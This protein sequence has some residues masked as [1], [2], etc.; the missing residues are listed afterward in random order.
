VT[1]PPEAGPD[2]A[3]HREGAPGADP[4]PAAPPGTAPPGT[5]PPGTADRAVEAPWHRLDPRMLVVGPLRNL[6]GLVPFA[7]VLLVTGQGEVS[8]LWYAVGAAGLLVLF[9]VLRW[10][11]T[12]YRITA[13]RVELRTGVLNRQRRSVPRDRIRTVDTTAT[14]PHR[15][16]GL[17][18]VQVSAAAAGV[19]GS[20]L[21]LDAVSKPEAERLRLVLLARSTVVQ[22]PSAAD[23]AATAPGEELAR[24]RWS[25]IRFA[26]LTVSS[27]VA[28]AAVVG[29]AVNLLDDLRVVTGDLVGS[30]G[31]RV[32][33]HPVVGIALLGVV[34]AAVA[35]VGAMAL[36]AER[37]FGY[38]LTREP[39][40]TL[41]VRRGLLTRRSLSVAGERLRGVELSEPL[42]LRAGRGAQAQAIST[43]L[44]GGG[45]GG[46]L[47]PPAPLAEGH[48]VASVVLRA[49]PVTRTPLRRHPRAALVRRLNRA[50]FGALALAAAVWLLDETLLG[51]GRHGVLALVVLLPAGLLL[52]VDRYRSLGHALTPQYLVSRRGALRRRTV[53]LQRRGVIGWTFRQSVFQRRSGIVTLEAVTAAGDGGYAVPDIG[54]ADAVAL[55]AEAVPGLLDPLLPGERESCS[56]ADR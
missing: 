26:P 52:G 46:A 19:D 12:C 48:R 34:L 22:T 38:R 44:A 24:L 15:I 55:A 31:E 30:A 8:T 50:V 2:V 41:R 4:Y 5:A 11:T 42:L 49:G 25:W 21:S 37:W 45:E 1:R 14:L 33:A 9:G 27:L 17:S 23:P 53:A 29:T 28:V 6:T 36:F 18:V 51:T 3:A 16:F 10:R 39:D 43:G 40:G 54:C 13:E 47:G 35:V 20:G 32:A 56:T 7:I